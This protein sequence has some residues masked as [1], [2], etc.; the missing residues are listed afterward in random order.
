MW[1]VS[2][3]GPMQTISNILATY[4][5]SPTGLDMEIVLAGFKK[6][7]GARIDTFQLWPV[8]RMSQQQRPIILINRK[9]ERISTRKEM[10]WRTV[11]ITQLAESVLAAQLTPELQ[12]K[13]RGFPG[14]AAY[15]QRCK[16]HRR[17]GITAREAVVLAEDLIRAT[18]K[19]NPLVG[20]SP[21]QMA[22]IKPGANVSIRPFGYP[23]PEYSLGSSGSWHMG[24][25]FPANYPFD[26]QN[27]GTVYTTC[28]VAENA[29]D[30]P[31]GD[32]LFYGDEFRNAT[33]IYR[34]GT[35]RFA[36]NIL[37]NSKLKILPGVDESGIQSIRSQFSNV[38]YVDGIQKP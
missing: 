2:L 11:G 25:V 32:S 12:G 4:G 14:I 1:F 38:E 35:V 9:K 34:G 6:D 17:D 10:I 22:T 26:Q 8:L 36:N 23:K 18:A 20:S 16:K 37:I 5:V 28:L 13:V 15:L 29:K 27:P 7:R 3:E 31:L 24:E 19:E 30:I 21:I 33:F